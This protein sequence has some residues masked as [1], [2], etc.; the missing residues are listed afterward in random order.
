MSYISPYLSSRRERDAVIPAKI[1]QH[2]VQ[3]IRFAHV[4]PHDG[5]TPRIVVLDHT[6]RSVC[7]L[8]CGHQIKYNL[9]LL[10]MNYIK[11]VMSF[12]IGLINKDGRISL[13]IT[14]SISKTKK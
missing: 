9:A 10:I 13:K 11:P 14:R 1:N 12:L 6:E 7:W 3:L 4:L 5:A 2:D 8:Q